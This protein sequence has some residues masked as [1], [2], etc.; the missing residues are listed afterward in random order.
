MSAAPFFNINLTIAYIS[1]KNDLIKK[2]I[3]V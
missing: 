3:R 1:L 2:I